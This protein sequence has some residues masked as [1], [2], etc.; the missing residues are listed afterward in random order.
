MEVIIFY[1]TC[2]SEAE[3]QKIA[4]SL[5]EERLIACANLYPAIKSLY[6]WEGKIQ[7]DHE[8]VLIMKTRKDLAPKVTTRVKELH[9]YECPCIL[10]F[11]V[12]E[13]YEPFIDWIKK[14]TG[15]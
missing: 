2:G 10:T 13:G 5:L 7:E 1:V 6:W 12:K 14:E 11:S 3:A 15:G 4:K 9:S 8:V